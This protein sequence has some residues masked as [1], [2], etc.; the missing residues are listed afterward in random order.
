MALFPILE[1]EVLRHTD[2]LSEDAGNRR[3]AP[4]GGRRGPVG[5]AGVAPDFTKVGKGKP[6]HVVIDR[7]YTGKYPKSGGLFQGKDADVAVVSGVKD[8]AV[9]AA[10]T[11][12]LNLV[13][14]KVKARSHVESN[15][16]EDGTPLILYSPAVMSDSLTL[17]IEMAFDTFDAGLLQ[18]IAGGLQSA[19]GIPLML[20]HAGFLLGA[21]Q[22]IKLAA[23]LGD[24]L[25]DGRPAFS[26]TETLNF[27]LPGRPLA[28][29]DF[30]LLT[31]NQAL[32][33]YK[34]DPAKGLLTPDGQRYIGDDPYVVISID[35]AERPDLDNFTP[36]AASSAVLQK[37]FQMR[38]RSVASVEAVVQG[39]Q[40]ASDMK[41]RK[42]A[43]ALQA[44]IAAATD[45]TVKSALK[46]ELDA[47]VKNIATDALKLKP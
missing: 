11:R 17:T 9:F 18:T 47:V 31:H 30:W 27:G 24:A 43:E 34:Y 46:T 2:L 29:A 23:G 22:L 36:T 4:A 32:H 42:Q 3:T 25:F 8:Y 5:T 15:A 7:V 19:A 41:L 40:L 10:S 39:L 6:L 26:I 28:V 45:D 33:G 12:A 14:R 35:G 13:S 1:N 21:G 20:P 16:F 44:R 38:E 37:F